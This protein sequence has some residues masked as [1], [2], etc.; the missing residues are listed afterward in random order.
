[1]KR[2]HLFSLMALVLAATAC[3][4]DQTT[5]LTPTTPL[6]SSVYKEDA[7]ANERTTALPSL[8]VAQSATATTT[9][10]QD[11]LTLINQKRTAGCNCG[12]TYYP[13]ARPLT[14]D[15]RLNSAADAHATDMTTHNFFS[16]TGSDGSQP[17]DRMT[18]AGYS[19]SYAGE[20]IGAG[21]STASAAVQGWINSPGHCANI[22]NPNF[23]NLGVGYSTGGTYRYYWVTDFAKPR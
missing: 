5:G 3:K 15:N 16:H 9:Q 6:T 11:V 12:T 17:W 22:M 10:Q 19:W 13:P 18:R 21:Y 14:L 4:Q 20:N 2:I 1:M 8:D 7:G 23:T